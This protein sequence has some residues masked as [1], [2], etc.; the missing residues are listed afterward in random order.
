MKIENQR[1]TPQELVLETPS[2]QEDDFSD[3]QIM[4][5]YNEYE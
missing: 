1:K 3:H 4:N 2:S 5:T